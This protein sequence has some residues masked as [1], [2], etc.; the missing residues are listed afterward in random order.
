MSQQIAGA[1]G[2]AVLSTIATSHTQSLAAGGTSLTDALIGGY[3]LAFTIGALAVAVGIVTAL[4][5]LRTRRETAPEVAPTVDPAPADGPAFDDLSLD[6]LDPEMI[7][8]LAAEDDDEDDA[9]LRG[10]LQLAASSADVE[11]Y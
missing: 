7:A 11:G 4:V 9:G 10:Y 3:H 1:L 2:L 6:L 8:E 5:V